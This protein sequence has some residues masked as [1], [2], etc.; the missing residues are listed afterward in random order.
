[1]GF[2]RATILRDIPGKK[3]GRPVGEFLISAGR[4][5][6]LA[7]I[8]LGQEWRALIHRLAALQNAHSSL[9]FLTTVCHCLAQAVPAN[10]LRPALFLRSSG[11]LGLIRFL[12]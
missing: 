10:R 1:M 2:R 12:I 6:S 5:P 7:L 9:A 4:F 11:T 8:D 3:V